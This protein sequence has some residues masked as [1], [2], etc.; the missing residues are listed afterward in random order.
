[1]LKKHQTLKKCHLSFFNHA[2]LCPR[3]T[4][5]CFCL[6]F[7]VVHLFFIQIHVQHAF[8]MQNMIFI[9]VLLRNVHFSSIFIYYDYFISSF[10]NHPF[11][12]LF[13]IFSVLFCIIYPLHKKDKT[14]KNK[15]ESNRKRKEKNKKDI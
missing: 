13:T 1:V 6:P 3:R 5:F 12:L 2:E 4:P 15:T 9:F 7:V 8:P 14:I 10:E 11:F